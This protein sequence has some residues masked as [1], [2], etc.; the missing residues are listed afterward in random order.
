ML[1]WGIEADSLEGG[2]SSAGCDPS[3]GRSIKSNE[4]EVFDALGGLVPPWF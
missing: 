3:C 2:C 1:A 4:L